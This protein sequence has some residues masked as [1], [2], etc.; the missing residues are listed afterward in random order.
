MA[1]KLKNF[2]VHIIACST[3]IILQKNW[4]AS[5]SSTQ[6]Q[7]AHAI[8]ILKNILGQILAKRCFFEMEVS[9]FYV[10]KMFPKKF[11]QLPLRPLFHLQPN[12]EN[13]LKESI[14]IKPLCLTWINGVQFRKKNKDKNWAKNV[15]MDGYNAC[16]S[17]S[18]T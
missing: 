3:I 11:E 4:K 9:C 17:S 8:T 18:S 2:Y 14:W 5:A 16:T 15:H 1:L 6:K 10:K 12:E 13:H 7:K